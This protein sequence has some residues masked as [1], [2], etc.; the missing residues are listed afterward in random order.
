MF[1]SSVAR[2]DAN[3]DFREGFNAMLDAPQK[4]FEIGNSLDQQGDCRGNYILANLYLSGVSIKGNPV[5][6]DTK[7]AQEL[8]LKSAS[9]GCGHS[10]DLIATFYAGGMLGLP[11]DLNKAVY[12]YS[13]AFESDNKMHCE[14]S[15][16]VAEI[17]NQEQ[18]YTEA[19]NW[20]LKAKNSGSDNCGPKARLVKLQ[21]LEVKQQKQAEVMREDP[22]VAGIRL[23]LGGES[24]PS[25]K[26]KKK[27]KKKN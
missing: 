6:S 10:A 21:E 8:L 20:Y 3:A 9:A 15:A 19:Y 17:Y 11:R 5:K 13:K 16:R 4:A 7:K 2:A 12:W 18:N 24:K 1:I 14:S 27:S 22:P 26:P 25:V 23:S